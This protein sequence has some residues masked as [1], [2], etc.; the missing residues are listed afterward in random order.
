LANALRTASALL[1]E[2]ETC[3]DWE[4]LPEDLTEELL[5]PA[6]DKGVS[7]AAERPVSQNLRQLSRVAMDRVIVA[8]NGNLSEAARR[9]GISRNTLYRK[10][11]ENAA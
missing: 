2:D 10:L 9:L 8:T 11:K 7:T 3:I 5:Q 1:D 6:D 4:H